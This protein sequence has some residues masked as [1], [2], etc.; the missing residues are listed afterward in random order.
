MHRCFIS[1]ARPARSRLIAVPDY[2]APSD[3]NLYNTYEVVVRASDGRL[4]DDQ[5]LAVNITNVSDKFVPVTRF[6][7][8]IPR[9]HHD[10]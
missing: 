6:G 5:S 8:G 1:I 7:S 2:E 4:S 9:Q 10:A 3:A